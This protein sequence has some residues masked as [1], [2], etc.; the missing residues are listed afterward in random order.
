MVPVVTDDETAPETPDLVGVVPGRLR[1]LSER[2]PAA[3]CGDDPAYPAPVTAELMD[4]AQARAEAAGCHLLEALGAE[5]ALALCRD[6][7]AGGDAPW[8]AGAWD[9]LAAGGDLVGTRRDPS[10]ERDSC[11]VTLWLRPAEGPR[12]AQTT[13][14]GEGVWRLRE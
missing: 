13:A 10:G 14:A 1:D 6:D 2:L 11:G 5:A 7:E 8:C 12:K 3:L 4:R 9:I